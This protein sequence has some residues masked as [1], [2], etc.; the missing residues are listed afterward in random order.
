MSYFS[1]MRPKNSKFDSLFDS[2]YDY[3][4][5]R[6]TSGDCFDSIKNHVDPLRFK[7]RNRSDFYYNEGMAAAV[8]DRSK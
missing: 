1:E 5:N 7:S 4:I 2:G 6:I 8:M 3:I